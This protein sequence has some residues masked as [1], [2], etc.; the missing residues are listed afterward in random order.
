ML[1]IST[2]VLLTQGERATSKGGGGEWNKKENAFIKVSWTDKYFQLKN[3]L[4][5]LIRAG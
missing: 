4:L 3:G 5:G 2:W 1:E